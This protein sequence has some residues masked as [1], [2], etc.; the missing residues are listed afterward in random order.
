MWNLERMWI[1]YRLQNTPLRFRLGADFWIHDEASLVADDDPRVAV[2]ATFGDLELHAAIVLQQES[3]R[4]GLSNDNDNI[5]YNFRVRYDVKPF[6]FTLAATYFRNRFNQS[7]ETDTFLLMP[8]VAGSI[9]ILSGM[10]QPMAVFG[11]VD[12]N[13]GTD[14]DVSAF[15]FIGILRANLA[16][17]KM[18]PF[19]AFIYGTGD[20]DPNDE[21]LEGFFVMPFNEIA[22]YTSSSHFSVF[23][24][25][26]SGGA[27]DVQTPALANI[28]SGFEFLHTVANPF[29]DRPGNDLHGLGT[30][31]A[32]NS[33]YSNPGTIHIAPGVT[34]DLAKGHRLSLMYIYRALTD[35]ELIEAELARR[36]GVT[37]NVDE[38]MSHELAADYQWA[39][40]RHFDLRVFGS[41]MFLGDGGKDIAGAQ[42]YDN[43]TGRRCEGEEVALHGEIRLRARF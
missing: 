5:F 14:Y 20:D 34:L 6:R 33:A 25:V 27:R 7:Q 38:S 28:G 17:G 29:H 30:P 22:P 16:G 43:V 40:S 3:L 42:V 15:G 11:S 19:L 9:G 10:I 26:Q 18:R 4:L 41:A 37:V 24:R 8:S 21:D 12:A 35:S 1:D 32:A 36:E 31:N 2:Y 13:G 23:N 39:P